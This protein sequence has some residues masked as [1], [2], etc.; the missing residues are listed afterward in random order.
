[1]ILA[2]QTLHRETPGA[3]SD[4]QE[5]SLPATTTS[6]RD[7]EIQPEQCG[8]STRAS[9]CPFF[10]PASK[11]CF[12]TGS[13][14][15]LSSAES[16]STPEESS[17]NTAELSDESSVITTSRL[18]SGRTSNLASEAKKVLRVTVKDYGIG[19]KKEYV[20]KL[21]EPFFVSSGDSR[22]L[23]Q[24]TG[25]GLA[26]TSKLVGA[27]GGTISVDSREGAHTAF[28]IE[29]PFCDTT[30]DVT[31][32]SSALKDCAVILIDPERHPPLR[33]SLTC[34]LNTYQVDF[35]VCGSPEE[36]AER[37]HSSPRERRKKALICLFEQSLYPPDVFQSLKRLVPTAAIVTFGDT[38]STDK[39]LAD[40]HLGPLHHIVPS[41][42]MTELGKCLAGKLHATNLP[43][44]SLEGV[45]VEPVLRWESLRVLVAE[46]HIVNQKVIVRMLNRLGVRDVDVVENGQQAVDREAERCYD[47][48]L[49]DLHM[50]IMDGIQACQLIMGRQGDRHPPPV[51]FVTAHASTEYE[52]QCREAGAKAFL[53]KPVNLASLKACVET[54]GVTAG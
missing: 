29:L 11:I 28:I 30:V 44:D 48:V 37:I 43:T 25:L 38:T 20:E 24:G 50:P 54:F 42:L 27:L 2:C 13:T 39:G 18:D 35:T 7:P 32:L 47:V 51:F 46:D 9:G 17:V 12:N 10:R 33:A 19:I 49:M 34:I 5:V 31:P 8:N 22:P 16:C 23:D 36:V 15:P 1:M 26:I 40:L 53:T 41:V 4:T 21:F 14:C 45:A 3:S 52:H 6:E